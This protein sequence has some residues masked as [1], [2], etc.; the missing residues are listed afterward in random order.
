M[1][2]KILIALV[3]VISVA[4]L[5]AC[6]AS[7][8]PEETT[9]ET[10]AAPETTTPAETTTQPETTTPEET[11]PAVELPEGV[12]APDKWLPEA[13]DAVVSADGDVL[14]LRLGPGSDYDP[15]DAIPDGTEIKIEA[16][17]ESADGDMTWGFLNY[18]DQY[19]WVSM[20][21]V[22]E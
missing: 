5:T 11:T 15:V 7:K 21:F 14:T 6:G 16:E 4:A 2:K 18:M 19:G 13:K 3:M 1:L 20:D 22:T 8:Q 12:V 9:P 17:Q 10:T